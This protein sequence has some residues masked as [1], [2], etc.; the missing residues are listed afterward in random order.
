MSHGIPRY[1]SKERNKESHQQELRKIET[2]RELDQL[3]RGK[4]AEHEYTLETLQKIS[5]L[6]G[7]NP[8]YYTVWNYRRQVLR[9]EF[10]R[11]LSN[12]S[13]ES[14]ADQIT[15]WIKKDLQFLIPL[16]RSF[17]KCYWIWNYR[18]WL[19][20]EARRLLPL[21]VVRR[22][23]EEEL[24]LL[25]LTSKETGKASR[26]Q[27]EFEYAKKMIGANLSNFSA[28][29]YRTKLIQRL[30]NEQSA[31]DDERRK[32]LDDELELIHRALCDPYDQSLWFYHQNLM[33][34]F[35]PTLC[36]QTMAPNL[37]NPERLDYLRREIDKIQD[38][39]DGAEDCKYIY[40]AL[41]DCTLLAAKVEGSMSS[42]DQ[43]KILGWLS[44][45]KQ[46]DPLRRGRWLD[47]ERSLCS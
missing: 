16:L 31:T 19:L 3:V 10:S 45:L 22:L 15:A 7:R 23:W 13:E 18:L 21:P 11:A 39:L 5:E 24:A 44:E 42:G 14:A 30:L 12:D 26:T 32:M 1:S 4:I 8:E 9:H 40:Q 38:M 33:C 28:W 6:L 17:P 27:E 35:V 36:E 37:S 25:H 20:D 2:Y 41:I 29:H 34:T 43:K 46:L 47:F